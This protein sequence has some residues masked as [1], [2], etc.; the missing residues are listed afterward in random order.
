VAK[1]MAALSI[2]QKLPIADS[3][4]LP[5]DPK[6]IPSRAWES[7]KH[8][9]DAIVPPVYQPQNAAEEIID[10]VAANLMRGVESVGG[11]MILT[12]QRILFEAHT[13]NLQTTPLAIPLSSI[14]TVVPSNVLGFVPTGITIRC[15]SGEEYRFVVGDRKR[16]ISRIE[17]CRGRIRG[18]G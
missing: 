15:T 18:V 3:P 14:Q 7:H 6:G 8:W 16:I 2:M 13:L 10:K 5:A 1:L 9:T 17:E 4:P 12:D 11:R